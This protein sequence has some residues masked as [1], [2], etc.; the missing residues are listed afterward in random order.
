MLVTRI[1]ESV[2]VAHGLQGRAHICELE[3]AASIGCEPLDPL[4]DI[5]FVEGSTD[6]KPSHED[7]QTAQSK[8]LRDAIYLLVSVDSP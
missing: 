6:A 3:S 7:S 5:C 4:G 2:V 8:A 1:P